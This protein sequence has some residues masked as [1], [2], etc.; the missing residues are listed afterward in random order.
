[1]LSIFTSKAPISPPSLMYRTDFLKSKSNVSSLKICTDFNIFSLYK[2]ILIE[3][4]IHVCLELGLRMT[5]LVQYK[6]N[7]VQ[8]YKHEMWFGF[9]DPGIKTNNVCQY[10]QLITAR[11]FPLSAGNSA[12]LVQREEERKQPIVF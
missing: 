11:S 6:Y 3:S 1:M 5:L 8:Y 2:L 9:R 4:S 10:S 12:V 7:V